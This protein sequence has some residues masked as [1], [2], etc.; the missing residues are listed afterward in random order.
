MNYHKG[1]FIQG[2]FSLSETISTEKFQSFQIAI[3]QQHWQVS[4]VSHV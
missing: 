1:L 2:A 4:I 3:F